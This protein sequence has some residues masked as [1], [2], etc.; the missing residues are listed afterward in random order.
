MI[1]YRVIRL[2]MNNIK[3]T[4]EYIGTPYSGWQ[5]QNDE[6][7][8]QGEIE[9][10]LFKFSGEQ[11][12]IQG[13][14]RTDAGVHALGQCANFNMKKDF[15]EFQILNGLNFHLGNEKIKISQVE[16]VDEDFNARFTAKTKTY[17]YQVFN[18]SSPSVL[19]GEFSIHI[20]QKLDITAMQTAINF[21]QGKHDFSAF[22]SSGCQAKTPIRSIKE[23]GIDI[24]ENKLIFIFKAQSF[25]YQQIRIMVGT[26]LEI[27]LNN[28]KPE[29]IQELFL[30]KNR[31]LAGPTMPSKGLILKGIQY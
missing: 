2:F 26:L 17:L 9:K 27:G 28:K 12:T 14:G 23:V 4:I 15:S 5:Y 25:L 30:S 11:I 19:E 13:A 21:F 6:K 18:S 7:T 10:A 16:K 29:W 8:I 1:L 31:A 24:K 20:R 3:L 22:R